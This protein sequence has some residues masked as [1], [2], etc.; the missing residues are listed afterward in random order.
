M[1]KKYLIEV[2]D[3]TNSNE[4][5]KLLSNE[6]SVPNEKSYEFMM[7]MYDQ[8]FSTIDRSYK[9]I[10]EMILAIGGG[11]GVLQLFSGE[12]TAIPVFFDVAVVGYIIGL[13]WMLIRLIDA[14]YW[15]NRNLFFI[16]KIEEELLGEKIND[17]FCDFRP[18]D[19]YS[20][21]KYRTSIFFQIY[22]VVLTILL[23][24]C[25]YLSFK[26]PEI[27]DLFTNWKFYLAVSVGISVIIPTIWVYVK[28]NQNFYKN[29]SRNN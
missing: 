9:N 4:A 3:V 17:I 16:H 28:R 29:A 26:F 5:S 22:F 13:F 6:K 10:W 20:K 18:K 7:H 11:I 23:T 12:K 24:V 2:E 21:N 25:S 8:M 19:R 14:N 1:K 27:K 15:C